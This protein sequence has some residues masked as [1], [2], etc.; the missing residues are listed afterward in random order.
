MDNRKLH[1]KLFGFCP[2]CGRWFRFDIKR[3]R[4]NTQYEDED[5]NFVTTCED[6]FEEIQSYWD[7]LWDW[8]YSTR[9]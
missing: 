6:C 5:L 3:R 4:Q 2:V 9:L 7:E 8:Y 1:E